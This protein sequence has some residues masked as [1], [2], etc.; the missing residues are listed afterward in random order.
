[1]PQAAS[2]DLTDQQTIIEPDAALVRVERAVSELRYGRPVVLR[3]RD[4]AI[5]L[6]AL[7]AATSA[8]FEQ[9]RSA[10]SNRHSLYLTRFRA[11]SLGLTDQSHGIIARLDGVDFTYAS[12]LAY[13]CDAAAPTQWKPATHTLSFASSQIAAVALLLPAFV[14]VDIDAHDAS[15]DNFSTL[16]VGDIALG[17]SASS[18]RLQC[19]ARSVV[20]LK[21]LGEC[22]IVV[23][24]GGVSQRDQ[25]AI[26]IGNPDLLGTVPV[27]IHSSCMTGDLL[28]SLKCDC[29]DQLRTAMDKIA[30]LG[31]G[32]L[33][34]L[35]QEGRGTGLAAKMRAY[36]YQRKG[37]DTIDADAQLG[38]GPDERS[39]ASAVEILKLLNIGKI[40]LL[41]NNPS[42][43]EYLVQ[44][45]LAVE[46]CISI[47]GPVSAENGDYLKTK[48]TRAN[49]N[50]PPGYFAIAPI[51]TGNEEQH[52]LTDPLRFGA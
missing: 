21:D 13:G 51:K 18:S 49:H 26:I 4:S 43:A 29:G 17:R 31:G 52:R 30:A 15:F 46:A 23:F 36:S 8:Q 25:T 32:V 33:I 1:M 11:A 9:F 2:I 28:G 14:F 24:R 48:A 44:H 20:P 7:D 22:E 37:L 10:A 3:D 12:R 38:F 50:F 42:K 45:G 40:S 35:D 39:Y 47:I 19:V 34:Y 5:A 16:W 6:L 27:R 41:S